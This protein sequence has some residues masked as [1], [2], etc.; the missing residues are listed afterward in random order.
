MG[1]TH[2]A[3]RALPRLPFLMEVLLWI[4]S[5]LKVVVVTFCLA[6]PAFYVA[7]LL[8][9]NRLADTMVNVMLVIYNDGMF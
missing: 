3:E 8:H 2:G 9:N 4:I 5:F 1:Q 6:A 7:I